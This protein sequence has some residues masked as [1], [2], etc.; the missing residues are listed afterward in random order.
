MNAESRKWE[1]EFVMGHE[2]HNRRRN[3]AMTVLVWECM[4]VLRD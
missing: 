2:Q 3:N 4:K 1:F